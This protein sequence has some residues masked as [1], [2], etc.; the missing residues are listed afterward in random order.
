MKKKILLCLFLGFAFLKADTAF[1]CNDPIAI[2]TLKEQFPDIFF[3]TLYDLSGWK[4]Q[5]IDYEDYARHKDDMMEHIQIQIH[6]V[7]NFEKIEDS[8]LAFIDASVTDGQTRRGVW[9]VS[10]EMK[11]G[12]IEITDYWYNHG[13]DLH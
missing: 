7:S 6:S 10:Y 9:G 5:G 12:K 4:G 1:E 8:C 11:E 2:K 13:D 3:R